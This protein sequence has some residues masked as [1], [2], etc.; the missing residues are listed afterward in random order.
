MKNITP[1]PYK[2]LGTSNGLYMQNLF[3]YKTMVYIDAI[4]NKDKLLYQLVIV[5]LENL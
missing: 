4:V 2:I 5:A 3:S 1:I